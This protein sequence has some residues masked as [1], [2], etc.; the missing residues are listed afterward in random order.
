MKRESVRG[1]VVVDG[2]LAVLFRRKNGIEYYSVPGGGIEKGETK[3]AALSRE[4]IEELNI[5]VKINNQVFVYEADDRIEYFF[6]CDYLD[7]T[8]ELG[9]EEKEFNSDENFYKADF[10][11]IKNINDYQILKEVKDYYVK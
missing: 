6:D 9:G 3:K 1:L 2:K 4:L 7:G 8:F 10:I 5:H 11:P